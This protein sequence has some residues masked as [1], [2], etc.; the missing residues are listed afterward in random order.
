M[1]KLLEHSICSHMRAHF[2]KYDILLTEHNLGFRSK[3]SF[4]SQLLVTTHDLLTRID[5]RQ[6]VDVLVLDFSKVF[7]TVPHQHLLQKLQLLGIHG[8]IHN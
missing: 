5:Q 8:C 7:D 2:E 4:E 3:H 6:N 1:C